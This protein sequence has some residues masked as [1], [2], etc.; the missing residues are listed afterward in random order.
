M[1]VEVVMQMVV[2]IAKYAH[3]LVLHTIQA[4]NWQGETHKTLESIISLPLVRFTSSFTINFLPFPV[5]VVVYNQNGT[6]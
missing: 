4:E 1:R 6:P 3:H 2:S 5:I